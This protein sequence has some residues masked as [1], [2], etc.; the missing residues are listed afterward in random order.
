MT[1]YYKDVPKTIPDNERAY[2]GLLEG[3]LNS[4]DDLS[5]MEVRRNPSSYLFRIATSSPVYLVPLVEKLNDLHNLLG[6]RLNYSK[7]I[8]NLSSI[9]FTITF[10]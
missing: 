5:T 1:V 10:L 3:V 6:I 9:S 7:S 2:F 4:T 8:K